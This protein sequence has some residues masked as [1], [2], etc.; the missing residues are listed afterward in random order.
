MNLNETEI[1][2][3]A[4]MAHEV[5]RSYCQAMGDDSQPSWDEAPDWQRGSA[6]A[7]VKLHEANPDATPEQSHEAWMSRKVGEGW[8]Y[9][10]KKLPHLKQHPCMVPYAELPPEQR[11]K[12]HIFRTT[13]RE[14]IRLVRE[15]K[16]HRCTTR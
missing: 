1:L 9:G 16:E 8:T 15:T 11:A 13:V 4:R 14:A 12:D 10:P 5:N 3:V 2:Q 7:G 6:V